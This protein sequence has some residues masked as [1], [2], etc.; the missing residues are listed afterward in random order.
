MAK[1]LTL[2]EARKDAGMT[3]AQVAEAAGLDRAT[4]YRIEDGRQQP[5][6]ENARS[7]FRIFKGRVPLAEI[8]DPKFC[9]E[10]RAA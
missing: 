7:L 1:K 10:V 8:Y 3:A 4:L 2:R 9:R 5:K 6:R